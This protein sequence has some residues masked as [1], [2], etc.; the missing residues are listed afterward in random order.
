MPKLLKTTDA[1][2]KLYAQLNPEQKT[3]VDTI[4]GPVLVVAGPGTGKTQVLTM[5]IA[6]ILLK[7]DTPSSAILALTFT[8]SGV[9]AMRERLLSIIGPEAYYVNICT[10]HSFCS[11]ILKTNPDKFILPEEVEPLSDLERVQTF[12]EILDEG[13]FK[14]IKPFGSKYYYVK[15]LIKTI[16][17]LK[18]EGI[19][20]EDLQKS[21]KTLEEEDK[22]K[23]EE[24]V[25][26][27]K[28]YQ[29]K[30]TS[31]GRYDFEDMIS[32][33][34][35]ALA[36]D[37]NLLRDYQERYLYILVDEYQ[38]TNTPQNTVV[39]L[40]S[41]FWGEDA[42]VFVVGDDAQSIYRFQGASVENILYFTNNFPS[43][44]IIT[45]KK[46]YRSQKT[47]I[48]AAEDV[49]EKNEIQLSK[50]LGNLD[51]KQEPA[52]SIPVTEIKVGH[53]ASGITESFFVANKI[54]ELVASGVDPKEIAVIYRNNLD[55]KDF[56]DM[57][58]RLGTSFRIVGGENI[59]QDY[60]I[61]K[62]L[63]LFD[64]ILKARKKDEDIDFFTI[65]NYEFLNLDYVDTLKLC[66]FASEKK[67]N[68]VEAIEHPDFLLKGVKA[69]HKFIDFLAKV[70]EWQAVDANET[71]VSF[72]EKVL[73]QSGFLDWVLKSSDSIEKLN[74]LNS[75]FAEIKKLN[76]ADHDLNLQKFME[77]IEILRESGIAI[78]EQDLNLGSDSILLTTAH[79]AKGLEFEY[80]FIVK[81]SDGKWG[82][83][84]NRELIKLPEGLTKTSSK[85]TAALQKEKNEDERR[86]FYVA[87]TRAK[88]EIFITYADSY[89]TEASTKEAV[90][91]MFISEIGDS[92]KEGLEITKYE[93][94]VKEILSDV[95]K[96]VQKE[97]LSIDEEEFIRENLKSL[98]ISV[99]SLNTYL[100][101]PYKFK[102]NTLFRTPRA[103][104]KFLALGT[105]V[106]SALEFYFRDFK[107]TG[108]LPEVD[109]LLG[110]FETAL[111]KEILTKLEHKEISEKG[112]LLL[113][114]YYTK[115][116]SDFVK[117]MY[118]EKFFG[119]GYGKVYLDGIS[120]TGKVDKIELVDAQKKLV[121]VVDYKTGKAKSRNDIEGKTKYSD[122]GY[123]RQ[124]VFYKLLADLDRSF[125]FKVIEAELD[126][127][128]ADKTGKF[129]KESFV[130]TDEEVEI[131]KK[132]IKEVVESIRALK[133]ERTSNYKACTNCE[134]KDH[135]W[136][137]GIP[138]GEPTQFPLF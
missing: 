84:K 55:S 99:T 76:L 77:N 50:V 61:N 73:E 131:L 92:L 54:K 95:I 49:I 86:L 38:D 40:L 13:S 48:E 23:L 91:S 75:L 47:I 37:E 100:E 67:L 71:F 21:L 103:K 20:P 64:V 120:L 80:V 129:T 90:P 111:A 98:S 42:N 44:Q 118:A 136:P 57:L 3:A 33:V 132:T 112:L 105:A 138:S 46:N 82:N 88:K 108:K 135:C 126:F 121:K 83:K 31:R 30:I 58:S 4:D 27:Y 63:K 56:A 123:K 22:A 133:F 74:R 115:Y 14:T 127:V 39:T 119:Y 9:R 52:D 96:P 130:I 12:R 137:E 69:P 122:G 2:V 32:L 94:A 43:A 102:L 29:R 116:K 45:L 24:V 70:E 107:D 101:C 97:A 34:T 1:F 104:D 110:Y 41:S 36:K 89:F 65:F 10:F 66:R 59:L 60:D 51:K 25:E 16:Q 19:S 72:F 128:E 11:E 26:V 79:K 81:C 62:L 87:L 93:N 106:H 15:S 68:F 6:N 5:R 18:R 17:D 8:E 134:Y 113:K 114:A 35:S 85:E 28:E 109:K 125:N 124:L 53:F 78:N 117:P 7:T